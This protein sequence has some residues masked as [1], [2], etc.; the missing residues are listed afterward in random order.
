M[1]KKIC[2]MMGGDCIKEECGW[3]N[4][5]VESCSMQVIPYNIYKHGN[6]I[7]RLANEIERLVDYKRRAK[8]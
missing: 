2:P 6:Q 4:V 3:Y 5:R 7:D 8:L 1:S